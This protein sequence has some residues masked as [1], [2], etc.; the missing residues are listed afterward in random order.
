[1]TAGFETRG[2]IP[3]VSREHSVGRLGEGLRRTRKE[4]NLT[5][6]QMAALAGVT[7]AAISQAETGRRGLS[8]DTIIP[9]CEALQMGIDD[10]LGTG[11]P[12]DPLLARHDRA[13]VDA[14]AVP[15]FN[16]PELGPRTFLIHIGAG[17]SVSPPFAHKGPEMVLVA[18]GLVLVDLGDTTP[19]LRSGD[20]LRVI[21]T[22]I[23]RLT[24]LST[25]Q[26]RLFWMAADHGAVVPS[27]S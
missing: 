9:L 21:R 16:D 8:L 22:S 14:G 24:N 6:A 12:P 5:Q 19:V 27:G 3:V 2:G 23:R 10:L 20:G 18:D 1:M 13:A 15:L 7:P 26:A 17:D 25:G 11:R 4:R